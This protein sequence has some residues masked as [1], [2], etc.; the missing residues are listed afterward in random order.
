[1]DRSL[2]LIRVG[3]FP[4]LNKLRQ[5]D[6]IRFIFSIENIGKDL[7]SDIYMLENSRRLLGTPIS[8]PPG[9]KKDEAFSSVYTVTLEDEQ[10]GMLRKPSEVRGKLPNGALVA[11]VSEGIYHIT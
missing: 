7:I 6:Q 4:G 5:G 3:I 2:T 10:R 11:D 9:E 1:M 8:L